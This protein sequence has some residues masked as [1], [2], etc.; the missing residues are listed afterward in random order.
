MES[1]KVTIAITEFALPAPRRGSIDANSGFGRG[2]E[3]GME[4]HQNTQ[5]LRAKTFPNYRAEV[6]TTQSFE[7]GGFHF[8]VSGRID[9]IF[10]AT[11][12]SPQTKIEEIKSSFNIYELGRKLKDSSEDHP[13]CLQ[14]KTYGYFHWLKTKEK[15]LLV[16]HLVSSRNGETMD[17]TI[18][19]DIVDYE[20]WLARRLEELVE[21]AQ[22]AE[23]RAKR[24]R[25]AAANFTFP[26]PQP[27]SGQ[28]EL[29][30]TINESMK[31]N[32]PLLIQAPTGLGKT[33]GVLYPTL[34]EAMERGQRV[35]YLT[36][37]NS[38]HSVAEDAIER[39]QES[40]ANIKSMTITAKSKMCFKNESICNP[41]YCEY[42]K[43]H[44]TKV[45]EHKLLEQLAK[46]RSLKSK[47]IQKIAKEHQVCPFELQ[48]DA[49]S[50]A[51][52]IICDYN[53]VFAPRSAFSRFSG[54]NID[55]QGKP[56]L[57]IDEAHNLPSRAMDYYSP[58][59][60]SF[61]LEQMRE[62]I[63]ALPRKFRGEAAELLDSCIGV[64]RRCG[65]PACKAPV[66]IAPPMNEFLE[67]DA[68]LRNFLS[69]YL[70]ADIDIQPRDV[71]LRL[72]FY[73]SAF[74]DALE[75]IRSDRKEFFTTFSPNPASITITCCDA[76]EM[77][78][79][80]YDQYDQVVAFSATLKPFDFYSQ[81][82]GLRSKK[83]K[84]AEFVSPFPKKNRK[85]L[86]IP[87]ISS[88]YSEREKNYPR[89]AETIEKITALKAGNYVAFFPSFDFMNRV[90][91]Q[92]HAPENFTVLQQQ[93][94]MRTDDIHHV[95]E[96]LN[97]GSHHILFAVQGGVFSEGVDYPG[98]ML[99]GAFIIGPPLPNF[100]LEREQMRE[101]Y[102]NN[103]AAGFDYAYAFPAMAKAVQAAGRVI[104]S[105]TD[106]GLIVLMD[107]RFMQPSFAKSM[108][109][110]WFT[111]T[112]RE[113][114]SDG[115]LRDIR[116]FWDNSEE[117]EK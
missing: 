98:D 64:L 12:E 83:L 27:R 2:T 26:F 29:I 112:P 16:L 90:L 20:A 99:I 54:L 75:F 116:L 104:R 94:H 113:L 89:I 65:P 8:E 55:Q 111:E 101:Y 46:K 81:L 35:I 24:R 96:Q 115:I 62:E 1:K 60:S 28:V 57:V 69:T 82:A 76:S 44:Y 33:V 42:A 11:K 40:G 53:Y 13:Y 106:K 37:K 15:P 84:T 114:V 61:V 80:A 59:L 102:E 22:L 39:L 23:K 74:S 32:Q 3:L 107:D 30:E 7:A 88:K 109:Q 100:G 31:E 34:R 79:D 41:D 95:L 6:P 105:E 86:L 73:W 97:N 17:V 51:D 68:L 50:E 91:S 72:S 9:G 4:I 5:E 71:V 93:R 58:S 110:D 92:F 47:T 108:P 43:D 21:E 45:A 66:R 52:A 103:Y 56:N 25:K 18:R 87:Q 14:L 36:P 48:I 70:A 67:Q 117:P 78:K 49:A 19:L 10:S 85:L 38:Q 77:L 63:K